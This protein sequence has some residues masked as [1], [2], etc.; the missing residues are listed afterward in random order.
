MLKRSSL[1]VVL[2]LLIG[3]AGSPADGCTTF[4]LRDPQRLVF[5]KNYDWSIRSGMLIVNQRWVAKVSAA[6]GGG[7]P[8]RWT[9]AYG[10]VTFNQFG[11]D[12]PMGGMNEAGL[13][14]EVMWLEETRYPPADDRATLGDLQW[15]QYQL[16]TAAT[17]EAVL[18]S[19]EDVRIGGGAPLHY[20]VADATGRVATV[21]FLDGHLVAHTGPSLP[22]AALANS[23]YEASLSYFASWPEGRGTSSSLDRFATA[24]AR[25][26]AFADLAP[27]D[28]EAYAFDTLAAVAQPVSTRWSIVYEI[29]ERRVHFRTDNLPAI[30]S[31]DMTDLDFACPATV[32]VLDLATVVSGDISEHLV[33]YTLE[34]NQ[35]LI[36]YAYQ[37]ISFLQGTPRSV[38]ESIARYPESTVCVGQRRVRRSSGRR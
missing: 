2:A 24:A 21:E 22:V 32:L 13:V 16:D 14:V 35:R 33:P 29:A 15:V 8:A 30:R 5:G 3:L 38:R 4:V 6:T 12:F 19:D 7:N 36:D 18:A 31:L 9:S 37:H 25:T 23:T 27:A 17:V 11:R 34:L 1:V 10:S 26:L 28:A 20:L